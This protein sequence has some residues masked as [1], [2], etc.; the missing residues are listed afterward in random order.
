MDAH[1]LLVS[2]C[3]GLLLLSL[4]SFQGNLNHLKSIGLVSATRNIPI[5]WSIRT[6]KIRVAI[7][8][9]SLLLSLY[10]DNP[11]FH[12]Q[13]LLGNLGFLKIVSKLSL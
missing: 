12:R 6:A 1:F 5:F 11:R 10:G 2:L 3:L 8:V 9:L 7:V 13:L 4:Q